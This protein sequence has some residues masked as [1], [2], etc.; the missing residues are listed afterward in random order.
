[1]TEPSLYAFPPILGPNPHTLILGTMPGAR[2]LLAGQYYGHPQNQFWRFMGDIF[3]A[4]LD[5]PYD[6]RLE[7]LKA[8]G[9]AVWDVFAACDREGSMDA[10]IKNG[11]INDFDTFL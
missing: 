4:G 3:G 8:A 2:S 7:I 6:E 11:V 5:K 10:D 1:M 9:I